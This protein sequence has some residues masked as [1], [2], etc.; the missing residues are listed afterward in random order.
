MECHLL[1]WSENELGGE[2]QLVFLS[3]VTSS[4]KGAFMSSCGKKRALQ[5]DMKYCRNYYFT[6]GLG[7]WDS[8]PQYELR[9][10]RELSHSLAVVL[11]GGDLIV[12]GIEK[13]C[14]IPH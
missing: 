5:P 6:C 8:M 1:D 2:A 7:D 10:F 13:H 12:H 3:A 11:R 14:R 9:P 4:C